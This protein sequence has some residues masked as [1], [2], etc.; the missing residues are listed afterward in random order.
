MS[1]SAA[2]GHMSADISKNI[3]ENIFGAALQGRQAIAV[4]LLTAALTRKSLA[5]AYLLSGR[6]LADKWLMARLV[7]AFLNCQSR[8]NSPEPELWS[9]L[10]KSDLDD[11]YCQNCRWIN[12]DEHPQAFLTLAGEGATGKIPVEKARKLTEELGKTSRYMRVVVIPQAE[13]DCLWTAPANALLKNIEEP[14]DNTLFLMF[15]SSPEQVLP[16]IIS[17]SQVLPTSIRSEVGFWGAGQGAH[18]KSGEK[19][20]QSGKGKK[21]DKAEKTETIEKKQKVDAQQADDFSSAEK[22]ALLKSEFIHSARKR[23]SGTNVSNSV[24]NIVTESH[25]LCDRLMALSDSDEDEFFEPEVLIDLL[26]AAELEVL[27]N[28]AWD[29]SN[30]SKYL[31]KLLE[32]GEIAKHQLDHYV[33]KNNVLETFA[34]SLTEL[35][36]KHL[37]DFRLVKN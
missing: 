27:R 10:T 35:R 20:S 31:T 6:A 28:T 36:L 11:S 17:R 7:A 32:L 15:A 21:T 29:R 5:N 2:S 25:E 18:E 14:Q 30:V 12:D 33:R 37:G 24:L 1:Q 34:Y 23:F 19:S 8:Q 9:C 16:T 26:C 4:R 13:Q 3:N 22:L